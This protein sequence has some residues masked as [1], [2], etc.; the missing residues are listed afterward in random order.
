[1]EPTEEPTEE[2][3]T[4]E[5]TEAP[6]EE[7]PPSEPSPYDG[8]DFKPEPSMKF[9]FSDGRELWT[10]QMDDGNTVMVRT[11]LPDGSTSTC[12]YTATDDGLYRYTGYNDGSSGELIIGNQPNVGDSA[13]GGA[14]TVT[15]VLEEGVL[16][17]NGDMI[18]TGMGVIP[19][20]VQVNPPQS[21]TD[22]E[23]AQ[24]QGELNPQPEGG[25]EEGGED[26]SVE[27]ESSPE[28]EAESEG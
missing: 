1:M 25:S 12:Y 9:T 3:P 8:G 4:E 26:A 13:L 27:G 15:Q 6:T 11:Y 16:L 7:A 17:S 18:L 19:G 2:A 28:G 24:L 5:P 23:L 10:M 14:A 21:L 22:E 20:S